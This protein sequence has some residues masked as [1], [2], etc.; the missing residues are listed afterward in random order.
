MAAIRNEIPMVDP[1]HVFHVLM[2]CN[3]M[4][5]DDDALIQSHVDC[6]VLNAWQTEASL[7]QTLIDLLGEERADRVLQ[8]L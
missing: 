3:Y 1:D 7:K 8:Q 6:I 5:F 2:S 4:A